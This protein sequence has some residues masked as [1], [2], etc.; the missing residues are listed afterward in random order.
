MQKFEH[1]DLF[2]ELES[3]L[4]SA[5]E[6]C[7][8]YAGKHWLMKAFQGSADESKFDGIVGRLDTALMDTQFGLQADGEKKPKKLRTFSSFLSLPLRRPR[9]HQYVSL[10][11]LSP[12]CTLHLHTL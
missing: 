10:L 8:K 4:E 3:T 5:I 6:L 2:G 11:P 7:S 12:R 9:C 1:S